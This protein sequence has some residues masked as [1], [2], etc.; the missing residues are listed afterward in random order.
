MTL[1]DAI[2][3]RN[4]HFLSFWG[5]SSR[6]SK[7]AIFPRLLTMKKRRWLGPESNRRHV[8]FQSTDLPTEL[9][10]RC[11][12]SLEQKIQRA[13]TR[14]ESP[15]QVHR[16]MQHFQ[17]ALPRN[18]NRGELFQVRCDPLGVQERK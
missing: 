8:D 7:I 1:H 13:Q 4:L 11:E 17:I 12:P 2:G 3:R 9:P 15:R 16:A 6:P 5:S 14:S 10:S 18:F